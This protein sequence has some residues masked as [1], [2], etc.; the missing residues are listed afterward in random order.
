MKIGVLA[1]QGAF[2]EHVDALVSDDVNSIFVVVADR[3]DYPVLMH[4]ASVK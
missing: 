1:V 4:A 2:A 3:F